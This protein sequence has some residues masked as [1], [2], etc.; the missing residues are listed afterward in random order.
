MTCE[1][2]FTQQ[3]LLL[4]TSLFMFTFFFPPKQKS[5]NFLCATAK[6]KT[7]FALECLAH[8]ND[9]DTLFFLPELFFAVRIHDSASKKFKIL[10]YCFIFIYFFFLVS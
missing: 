3:L 5:E 8:H 6:E 4:E 7:L 2:P 1:E 9:W 10:K